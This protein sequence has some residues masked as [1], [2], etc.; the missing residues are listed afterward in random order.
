MLVQSPKEVA[1][2]L[3]SISKD[4][5]RSGAMPIITKNGILIGTYII[6]PKNGQY[7]VKQGSQI[8]YSTY[9]KSAAMIIARML[10]KR[11]D[12]DQIREVLEADRIAFSSRQDLEIF[13]HQIK[14]AEK[15]N[16][17]LKE[18]LYTTR[19]EVTNIKYQQ[20]K[21]ILQKSYSLLF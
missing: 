2:K 16:N 6:Q 8:L 10:T 3:E 14:V 7:H 19:F 4:V 1:D 17:H 13:K 15:K 18:E 20:A 11:I 5:V 12:G 9:S 21:F